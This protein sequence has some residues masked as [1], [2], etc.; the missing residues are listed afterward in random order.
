MATTAEKEPATESIA[1]RLKHELRNYA[2]LSLYLYICF[3]AI[4]LY[5][6]AVLGGAGV[7][8]LPFGLPAIKALI[9]AKFILLGQ[10]IGLGDRLGRRRVLSVIAHKAVLY[11][12]LLVVLT[13]LEEMVVGISHGR[14]IAS[15]L[16][17][18]ALGKLPETLA[19][20]RTRSSSWIGLMA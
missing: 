19:T 4:L 11:L 14:T 6:A 2:L 13:I 10:V 18:F 16:G 3:A 12:I 7:S 1:H 8:Y 15:S 20:S 5:K 17:E 9:L